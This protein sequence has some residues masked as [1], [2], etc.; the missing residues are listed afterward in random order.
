MVRRVKGHGPPVGRRSSGIAGLSQSDVVARRTCNREPAARPRAR[1]RIQATQSSLPEVTRPELDT[2]NTQMLI[3]HWFFLRAFAK[4]IL[5][6]HFGVAF[7]GI[8]VR[9]QNAFF[10]KLLTLMLY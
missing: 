6:I 7:G 10:D 2:K 8:G 1:P 5:S 9:L 4:C 3:C